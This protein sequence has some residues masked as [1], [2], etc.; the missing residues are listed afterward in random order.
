MKP[1]EKIPLKRYR[2][3]TTLLNQDK[4]IYTNYKSGRMPVKIEFPDLVSTLK[5]NPDFYHRPIVE[6]EDYGYMVRG[7]NIFFEA[8]VQAGLKSFICDINIRT[9]EDKHMSQFQLMDVIPEVSPYSVE[10]IFFIDNNYT[11]PTSDLKTFNNDINERL[12]EAGI[13]SRAFF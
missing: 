1:E 3:L 12:R 7:N 9:L 10:K 13:E 8:G 6:L 4:E 11:L 2:L 5:I